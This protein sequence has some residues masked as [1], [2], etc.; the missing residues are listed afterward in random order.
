MSTIEATVAGIGAG[1]VV[2]VV[3]F[4]IAA[5]LFAGDGCKIFMR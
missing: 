4:L 2:A 3:V 1:I 5:I